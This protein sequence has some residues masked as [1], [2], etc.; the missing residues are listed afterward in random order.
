MSSST[1]VDDALLQH[2]I[3]NQY[4]A[5]RVREEL[6]AK[7]LDDTTISEQVRAFRKI[8]N[9]KRQ[10]N[11]FVCLSVGAVLGFISCTLTIINP[12]PGLFNWILY[13]LTSIAIILIL[14]GLYYL[15]E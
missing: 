15:L 10:F 13:G 5:L 2:W 9:A 11:G 8:K 14:L 12:M 4:D 6:A 3:T 1:N 7:G